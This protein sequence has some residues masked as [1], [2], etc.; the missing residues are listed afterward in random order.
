MENYRGWF[1]INYL[2]NHGKVKRVC[3]FVPASMKKQW[4]EEMK[5]LFGMEFYYHDS[6]NKSF[7]FPGKENIHV[8]ENV[9]GPD[10]PNLTI[11]SWHWA[12]MHVTKTTNRFDNSALP[13]LL[14]VD[15]AHNA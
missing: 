7:T 4:Q 10:S 2:L 9:F 12:R 1:V 14:I 13:E 6:Q 15:A 11:L 8:G 5:N 3:L